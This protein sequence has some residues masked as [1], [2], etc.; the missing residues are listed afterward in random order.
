MYYED[1]VAD[2]KTYMKQFLE[3]VDAKSEWDDIDVAEHRDLSVKLY[4]TGGS[5][6]VGTQTKGAPSLTKGKADFKFHQQELDDE[7]KQLLEEWFIAEHGEIH[8]KYL[9]RYKYKL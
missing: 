3:F 1:F 2:P 8:D 6:K 7:T 9:S 5:E 4:E